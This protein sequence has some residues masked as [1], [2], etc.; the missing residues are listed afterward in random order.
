[1]PLLHA[2]DSSE[3]KLF[4]VKVTLPARSKMKRGWKVIIDLFVALAAILIAKILFH[5]G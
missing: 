4:N 5:I 2:T 1:M 3:I